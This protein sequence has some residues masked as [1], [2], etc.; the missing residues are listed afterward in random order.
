M[1]NKD[2]YAYCRDKRKTEPDGHKRDALQDVYDYMR[3]CGV[4]KLGV[5]TYI[6]HQIEQEHKPREAYAW[7]QSVFGTC[8]E[9]RICP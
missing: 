6:Q 2:F 8:A 3:E 1:N 5:A 7:I 9:R 4:S